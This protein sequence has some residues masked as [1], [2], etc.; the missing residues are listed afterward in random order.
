M[1]DL[2]FRRNMYADPSNNDN[3]RQDAL[4]K[5]PAKQKF[6][7]EI[8]TLESKI[9]KALNVPVPD[10]L[11]QKL[12]LK[13]T[14]ANHQQKKRKTRFHLALA[15]SIAMTVGITYN[16]MQYS[17]A[18]KTISD[19]A[20]AHVEHEA[21]YFH[22]NDNNRVD[23]ISLNQKMASFHG[24]FT[25]ELGELIA[26]NICQ[27]DGVESLHLVFKGESSPVNIF[28]VPNN[29]YLN[30]NDH[31]E[32]ETMQGLVNNYNDNNIIIVGDKRESLQNWQTQIS[33]KI[34]W[35]T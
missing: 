28:V 12:L 19:Y 4:S 13:Q 18:Y 8:Y 25:D 11:A 16:F 21:K 32:N 17:H 6:A 15:A 9:N 34:H 24:S 14:L 31:F 1:D 29:E 33:K 30:I 5:D 7:Q 3:E 35:S 10:G 26:V 20:I 23:L 22:N 27:F 2:Q